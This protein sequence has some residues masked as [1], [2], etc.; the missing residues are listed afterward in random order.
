MA[1]QLPKAS[2]NGTRRQHEGKV[3][4]AGRWR[5][6]RRDAVWHRLRTGWPPL[7]RRR[8]GRER[9]FRPDLRNPNDCNAVALANRWLQNVRSDSWEETGPEVLK[10]T[11]GD[12]VAVPVNVS[13]GARFYCQRAHRKLRDVKPEQRYRVRRLW[14]P[15]AT[16]D[17]APTAYSTERR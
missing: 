5:D 13:C 2:R 4:N 12:R 10:L 14:V 6:V 8:R 7:L 11:R 16:R 9:D 15:W 17:S 3:R 1:S